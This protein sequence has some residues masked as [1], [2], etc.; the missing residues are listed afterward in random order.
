MVGIT[1]LFGLSY[2][3]LMPVFAEE[4]LKV[5]VKGLGILM[6][7]AGFGALLA[8]LFLARLENFERKGRLLIMSSLTYSV[9]LMLFA[10]S[11]SY[12]FSLFTLVFVGWASVTAVSLINTLLQ[13]M[14][15]DEFRGRLMSI[16]MFVFAGF[17]PFGNLIA[18]T[19]SEVWGVSL[20]VLLSGAICLVFFLIISAFYPDLEKL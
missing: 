12:F 18:G 7:A 5:G 8:A 20:T 16:F 15:P 4:V 17:V 2:A 3:I 6:S 19:L 1:S 11:R 10:A 14:A 9:S 13:H